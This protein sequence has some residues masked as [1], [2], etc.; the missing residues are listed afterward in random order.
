MSLSPAL[1]SHQKDDWI[2]ILYFD[3]RFEHDLDF[4]KRSQG[5]D[6][7]RIGLRITKSGISRSTKASIGQAG[8]LT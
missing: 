8:L 1:R 3:R 4:A 2:Y 7:I 6:R 5:M